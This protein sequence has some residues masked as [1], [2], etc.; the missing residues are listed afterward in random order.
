MGVERVSPLTPPA[1][2]SSHHG[3]PCQSLPLL[4]QGHHTD[5]GQ[6]FLP[7][8][9]HPRKLKSKSLK[10]PRGNGGTGAPPLSTC[11]TPLVAELKLLPAP[12]L[13][14]PS[15][16]PLRDGRASD[17][18]SFCPTTPISSITQE[19]RGPAKNPDQALLLQ[20]LRD[21]QI[22]LMHS[23]EPY[24]AWKN[25]RPKA[26]QFHDAEEGTLLGLWE[27]RG[28]R[29][30]RPGGSQAMGV[31]PEAGGPSGEGMGGVVAGTAGRGVF[32]EL[33]AKGAVVE[34]SGRSR[35]S[36]GRQW[37]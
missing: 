6:C 2:S 36:W 26:G 10:E 12:P 14:W 20:V 3:W 18:Q 4:H 19:D 7:P 32:L 21:S 31:V 29:A 37:W 1:H 8:S 27:Q 5:H 22:L 23:S 15:S 9:P 30:P 25:E 24:L 13:P 33:L 35:R 28:H 11:D 34:K 16:Q 17:L